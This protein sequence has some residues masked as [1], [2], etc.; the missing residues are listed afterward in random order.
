MFLFVSLWFNPAPSLSQV[1]QG[2]FIGFVLP[3]ADP[4]SQGLVSVVPRLAPAA[5]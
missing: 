2:V 3:V 5:R 1:L 4:S